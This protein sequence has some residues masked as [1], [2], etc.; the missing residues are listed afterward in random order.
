MSNQNPVVTIEGEAMVIEA[1]EKNPVQ[2]FWEETVVPNGKQIIKVV[3]GVVVVVGAV[4]GIAKLIASGS[5]DYEDSDESQE[6][7]YE[8]EF[9]ENQQDYESNSNN[10]GEQTETEKDQ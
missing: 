2:K 3:G 9:V 8:V 10:N 6:E 1:E 7:W 5:D 4:A